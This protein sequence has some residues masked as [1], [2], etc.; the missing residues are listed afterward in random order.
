[1]FQ[2]YE[3]I[4]GAIFRSIFG[5]RTDVEFLV[6]REPNLIKIATS[7]EAIEKLFDNVRRLL[8]VADPVNFV[9][10]NPSMVLDMDTGN[11]PSAIDGDLT[12]LD[13]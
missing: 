1:M 2:S 4:E 9:I 6:A 10:S 8:P 13:G 12:Q 7:R 5:D 3:F 11:L